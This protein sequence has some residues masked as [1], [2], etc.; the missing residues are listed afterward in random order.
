MSEKIRKALKS[1]ELFREMPDPVI[2]RLAEFSQMRIIHTG[3]TLFCQGEPSP[4]CFGVVLGE[5]TLQ[6]VSPEVGISPKILAVVKPGSLFGEAA[7]FDASHR[8]AMATASQDGEV[9]AISGTKLRDWIQ[10]NAS[11][12]RDLLVD[13]L[14]NALSRHP[15]R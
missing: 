3:E 11:P 8:A 14:K 5:V 13:L 7:L 12:D 4:Y 15:A 2:A 9:V 1:I 10:T 6:Q